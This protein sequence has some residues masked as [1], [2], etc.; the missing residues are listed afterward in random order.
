MVE[1]RYLFS[2]RTQTIHVDRGQRSDDLIRI[3]TQFKTI[4]KWTCWHT[5]L[6]ACAGQSAQ[7]RLTDELPPQFFAG[8]T[9]AAYVCNLGFIR[10]DFARMRM[11]A[12]DPQPINF[13]MTSMF[14]DNM[15]VMMM[16]MMMMMT[17]TMT[18]MMT[19]LM[20]LL[21]MLLLLIMILLL[22]LLM[23]MMMMMMMMLMMMMLML[24]MMMMMMMMMMIPMILMIQYDA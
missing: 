23:L 17:M 4:P 19:M 6:E 5:T 2:R 21:L 1:R 18:T 10:R 3:H 11:K 13:S 16:M 12:R 22:L 8:L 15:M 7:L 14:L 9:R 24:V 20:M